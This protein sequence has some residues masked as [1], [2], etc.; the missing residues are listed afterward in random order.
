MNQRE[1]NTVERIYNIYYKKVMDK[2]LEEAT[3]FNKNTYMYRTY[4]MDLE[5]KMEINLT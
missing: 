4:R 3:S 5:K 1:R 2:M